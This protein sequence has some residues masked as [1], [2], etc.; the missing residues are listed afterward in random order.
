MQIRW[1]IPD[2]VIATEVGTATFTFAD[3][4][5]ATFAY[6]VNGISQSKKITR[7]VFAMPGNVCKSDAADATGWVEESRG[8]PTAF[9]KAVLNIVIHA[10]I[11]RCDWFQQGDSYE[12]IDQQGWSLHWWS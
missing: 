12:S 4:D 6:T 3:G 5:S 10:S 8:T 2:K 11:S 1:I 9:W 7:E